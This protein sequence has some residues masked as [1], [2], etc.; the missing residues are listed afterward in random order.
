MKTLINKLIAKV[1]TH[2]LIG[3]AGGESRVFFCFLILFAACSKDDHSEYDPYYDWQSRNNAWFSGIAAQ[4]RDEINAAKKQY[5]DNWTDHCEWRMY[6]SL[7]WSP[8]YQSGQ[9]TDSICMRLLNPEK[10]GKG[11]SYPKSTDVV[12]VAFQGYLMPT[13]DAFGNRFETMF[14]NT[15]VGNFDPSTA[16]FNT[17][18]VSAYLNGFYTALHYMVAG[19]SWEVY[20]PY[21]LFYGE[22]AQTNIPAYSSVRFIIHRQDEK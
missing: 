22:T 9:V 21:Q 1:T 17:T 12:S 14:T 5:G 8:L 15:Y 6:K 4:A 3:R 2:S 19:D 20:I 11:T 13:T 16:T 10:T 18:T 7:M